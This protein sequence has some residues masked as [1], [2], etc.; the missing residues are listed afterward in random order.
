MTEAEGCV[1]LNKGGFYLKMSY[2]SLASEC[3]EKV[4]EKTDQYHA[5]L[6]NVYAKNNKKV[7]ESKKFMLAKAI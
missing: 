5:P 7:L 3:Y 4:I 1:E 2:F 6:L